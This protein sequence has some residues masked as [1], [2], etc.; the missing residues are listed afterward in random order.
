MRTR[1]CFGLR[2]AMLGWVALTMAVWAVPTRADFLSVGAIS[3]GIETV[4]PL[5]PPGIAT[6][7]PGPL[8][9]LIVSTDGR[10]P[11]FS[12]AALKFDISS[13]ST[14]PQSA[15]IDSATFTF[16]VSGAQTVLAQPVLQVSGG[17]GSNSGVISLSDFGVGGAIATIRPPQIP[18]NSGPASVDI[19]FSINVT[20]II[21]SLT[22]SRTP[23]AVFGF[24]E[25]SNANVTVWGSIPDSPSQRPNL[26][27]T[28][29]SVPEPASL[30]LG[31]TSVLA[32][33]GYWWSRRRRRTVA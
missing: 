32:G 16:H 24:E 23:F 10:V 6:L 4:H 5:P 15:T 1:R 18:T 2:V 29:T 19:P 30:A 11:I 22:N 13:I 3:E 27:I 7:T 26:A 20:S 25:P 21:Q 31:G 17:T 33:L 14:I 9:L 8:R 12:D 28:F